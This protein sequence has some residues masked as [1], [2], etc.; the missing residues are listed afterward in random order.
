M[1]AGDFIEFGTLAEEI[2]SPRL[3]LPEELFLYLCKNTKNMALHGIT[4]RERGGGR[5]VC[6]PPTKCPPMAYIECVMG[7]V[8]VGHGTLMMFNVTS[9]ALS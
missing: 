5:S 8:K 2:K 7:V 6:M 3:V 4:S 1:D 9:N